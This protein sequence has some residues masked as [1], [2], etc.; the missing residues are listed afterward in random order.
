MIPE[1]L[2]NGEDEGLLSIMAAWKYGQLPLETIWN[3]IEVP[4]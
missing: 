1:V 2:R 4:P 3:P